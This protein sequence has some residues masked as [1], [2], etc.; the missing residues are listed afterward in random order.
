MLFIV[1][2][3]TVKIVVNIFSVS[4]IFINFLPATIVSNSIATWARLF[5]RR[6]TANLLLTRFNPRLN[7]NRGLVLL[8]KARLALSSS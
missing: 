2:V 6:L 7:S 4:V 3:N 8:F 5:E 1:I